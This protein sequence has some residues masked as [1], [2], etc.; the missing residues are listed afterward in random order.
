MSSVPAGVRTLNRC[1]ARLI[2]SLS[3]SGIRRIDT[4]LLAFVGVTRMPLSDSAMARTAD[5]LAVPVIRSSSNVIVGTYENLGEDSKGRSGEALFQLLVA[6]Y[7]HEK[8]RRSGDREPGAVVIS[9][10][11]PGV[12][13]VRTRSLSQRFL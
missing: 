8:S 3:E 12:L 1:A 10:P 6:V 5:M 2:C 9:M 13:E 4:V 11:A 7:D